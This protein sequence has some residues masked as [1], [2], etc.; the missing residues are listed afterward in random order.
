MHPLPQSLPG[1]QGFVP[2][3]KKLSRVMSH[4]P[5][6]SAFTHKPTMP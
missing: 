4:E 2:V 3:T 6:A 5:P 1:V